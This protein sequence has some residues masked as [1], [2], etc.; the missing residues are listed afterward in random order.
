MIKRV[1][2]VLL[3]PMLTSVACNETSKEPAPEMSTA[4]AAGST[5]EAQESPTTGPIFE[6]AVDVGFDFHHFNG[7][8]GRYYIAE[9]TGSGVGLAD[10]DNDGDLDVYMVQG[11]I[12]EPG[13]TMQD[14][15]FP[16]RHEE[17]VDRLYRNELV[18]SG[19]LRFTDVTESSG[20]RAAGYGMAVAV[21]DVENDGDLD[22]YVT[23]FG[24]NQLWLNQGD[25]TFREAA[26]AAG[27]D[28]PRWSVP[29][30]FLDI[31]GDG[32]SDLFVGNYLSADVSNPKL[33]RGITGAQDYCGP[34]AYQPLPDRLYRNRGDGT[35]EDVTWE[36]GLRS[37]FGPA[38][39]AVATDF[40]G[41]GRV[42]LYVANDQASNQLWI[43]QE[44]GTFRDEALFS[45]AAVNGQGRA[46]ASMGVDAA[47][48]DGDG[49][50]DLFMT[51]LIGETNTLYVNEGQGTFVDRSMQWG[52]ASPSRL[53]TSFGTGWI[54]VDHDS[55]LDLVVVNGA[56]KA[57]EQLAVA[58]DPYPY[59]QPN[60]LFR[61]QGAGYEE[62]SEAAGEAL[63][64]S[65]VS[66]GLAIGDLD[67]D[68]DHDLVIANNNGPAR[69]LL[70]RQGQDLP[71]IG[72]EAR[73]R[74]GLAAVGARVALTLEDGSVIWRRVRR[75]GS[76]AGASDPRALFG[77]AGR[78][79]VRELEI[80]WPSGGETTLGGDQLVLGTYIVVEAPEAAGPAS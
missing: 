46:E 6:E 57:V 9:I 1:W 19:E 69:L 10:F 23:N 60:Q 59:H 18:P 53:F 4:P 3:L 47:D 14:T 65:E 78:A 74:R 55:Y 35:F 12:L 31:D 51:H 29:A 41:D 58:R 24:P 11:S 66:R 5:T 44:D 75:D 37:G 28:E 13:K 73:R 32:F 7:A 63:L 42:D 64:R 43:R 76:Y 39:G 30:V 17:I 36:S 15:V 54:D 8:T 68:G 40:N 67:N 79:P 49:D 48:F 2:P 80:H 33:C 45:G 52:L 27:I 20:L 22:L 56:V 71:W 16:A 26:A 25:G 62:I 21:A 38:L 50:D 61:H 77:L 70:N 72:V 34:P